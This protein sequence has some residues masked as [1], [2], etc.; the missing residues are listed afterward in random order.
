MES[1]F[2]C[3]VCGGGLTREAGRYVC[4]GGHSFDVAREGYVHL[5]SA[6]AMEYFTGITDS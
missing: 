5:L 1:P 4:P 3:S 2:C 6:T